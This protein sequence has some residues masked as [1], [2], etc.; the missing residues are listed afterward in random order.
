MYS[1]IILLFD[2][3][4]NSF[5][6]FQHLVFTSRF[7]GSFLYSMLSLFTTYTPIAQTDV[8]S[9]VM[10]LRPEGCPQTQVQVRYLIAL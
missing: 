7:A 1:Y 6:S 4:V 3:K 10:G 5:A 2:T 8:G 9:F